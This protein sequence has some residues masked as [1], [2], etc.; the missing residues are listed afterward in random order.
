MEYIESLG[1]QT[2]NFLFS[3]GFGLIVGI[4]YDIVRTVRLVFTNSKKALY[5]TDFLFAVFSA[6]ATFLFC[7]TVTEGEIRWY[8]ILG[9]AIGFSVYYFSFG[10]IA[11]RFTD[12]T[13]GFIRKLSKKIFFV[14][15]SPFLKLFSFF[16]RKIGKIVEKTQKN[17]RKAVKKS[18]FHLQTDKALL[19]NLTNRMQKLCEKNKKTKEKRKDDNP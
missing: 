10:I 4:S 3:L 13:V 2:G 5:V 16:K 11:V 12:K 7:L 6:F 8:V 1:T 17:T 19:Y 18:K 9:E 14:I 15:S